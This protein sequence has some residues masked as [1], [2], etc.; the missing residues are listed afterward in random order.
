MS[1]WLKMFGVNGFT[2]AAV[3]LSDIELLL[4]VLLLSL[5]CVWTIVK[6]VKLLKDE[7]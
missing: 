3:S 2:I 6:I 7:K 1:E 5:T 4:K